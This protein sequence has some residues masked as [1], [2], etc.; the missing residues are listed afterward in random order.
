MDAR[1]KPYEVRGVAAHG[2][3][4]T[5]VMAALSDSDAVRQAKPEIKRL[6][7]GNKIKRYIVDDDPYGLRYIGR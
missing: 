6:A 7:G 1:M 4:S 2:I 3:Y 5:I